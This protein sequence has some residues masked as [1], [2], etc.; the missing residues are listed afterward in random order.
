MISVEGHWEI[1]E[2]TRALLLSS[3]L[4]LQQLS[5]RFQ[6]LATQNDRHATDLDSNLP[7]PS[8][9]PSSAFDKG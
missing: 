9:S 2:K 5:D 8:D 6:E 4:L 3:K 7:T 1:V